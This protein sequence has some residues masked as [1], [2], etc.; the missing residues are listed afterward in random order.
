MR[1]R[2]IWCATLALAA[3]PVW[4]SEG[5]EGGMSPFAGD[6]GNALWTIAIFLLVVFVLGRFAWRPILSG[7]QSRE[8]FIRQSI[9]EA[10][11]DRA[12]AE[13]RLKQYIDKLNHARSEATAIVDEARRDADVVKQRIEQEASAEA[14]RI[15]ERARREIQLATEGAVKEIY[16]LTAK[17]STQVASKILEREITP[18]DHERLIRESIDRLTGGEN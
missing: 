14:A 5:G 16:A 11:R 12:E 13:E 9:E 10:R 6:V 18:Q 4:A 15:V 1:A 7:L 3:L 8:S 2:I 17:L